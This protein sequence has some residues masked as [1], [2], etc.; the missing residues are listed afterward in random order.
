MEAVRNRRVELFLSAELYV[1]L[2]EVI[3]RPKFTERLAAR[4]TTPAN[5][6][7]AIRVV[8]KMVLPQPLPLPANLRDADDLVVLEC[9]VAA[10]AEAIV[11]GDKDLLVMK[12]IEGI[13]ILKVREALEK[14]G[15]AAE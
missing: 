10:K 15:I 12:S 2:E 4:G 3:H 5:L 13:P 14:L 11:T 9:A 7:T 1:E 8:A 6:L